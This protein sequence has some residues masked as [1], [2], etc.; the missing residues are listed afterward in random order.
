MSKKYTGTTI[1]SRV[2]KSNS[3]PVLIKKSKRI[4]NLTIDSGK[5]L[6][7]GIQKSYDPSILQNIVDSSSI[8]PQC[9]DA[10]SKNIA[11][12]G[13]GV[14]AKTGYD[15]KDAAV[16]KEIKNMQE[17]LEFLSV[18]KPLKQVLKNVLE[19]RERLGYAFI[20]I[21]RNLKGEIIEIAKV[22]FPEGMELLAKDD[23]N[24]SYVFRRNG[25]EFKRE[26]RF[27]K[28]KQ[29]I[30]GKTIYF[31]EFLDPRKIS[32]ATGESKDDLA[33]DK[34]A[35]EIIHLKIEKNSDIYG[36]PRWEGVLISALGSRY[37][38]KLNLNYFINGRHTPLAILVKN[39][40]LTDDAF[41]NIQ[42]YMNGIKGEAGQHA[43]LLLEAEK[44]EKESGLQDD[45]KSNLDI[46]IQPLAEILQ[47][48]EL[49]QEYL[50]NSRKKIQSSFLLPDLYVGYTKDFNVATAREVVKNTEI[51]V[52]IPERENLGWILNNMI[53]SNYNFKMCECYLKGPDM[54]NSDH[55]KNMFA[56][57][58]KGMTLNQINKEYADTVNKEIEPIPAE[59]GG[60]LPLELAKIKLQP[61]I[62]PQ[63]DEAIA[64]AVNNGDD[65]G[66][67]ILKEIK[68]SYE[69][70][71]KKID[72]INK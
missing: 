24:T 15:K 18:E 8:L 62:V 64:K 4:E 34:Q 27:R 30:N 66:I 71:E 43:F 48:D 35:N 51:Q 37:A 50:Q 31:K 40:T 32:L 9:V 70:L 20:E 58:S 14:R 38:E 39:G 33:L 63:I 21:I 11:G 17:I 56:I 7:Y 52:F 28:Y 13:V 41:D 16:E 1:K 49:F 67:S 61:N 68:K 36:T 6:V 10:F 59:L 45:E 57:A 60:D 47:K 72:N 65:V 46:Q 5:G 55:Q 25:R 42:T 3:T 29:T 69:N 19:D 2:I 26:K 22:E 12:F 54:N 44:I 53:L 23:V